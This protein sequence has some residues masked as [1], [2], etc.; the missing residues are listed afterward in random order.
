M[1]AE[2]LKE[3]TAEWVTLHSGWRPLLARELLARLSGPETFTLRA[4]PTYVG[5]GRPWPTQGGARG[6]RGYPI[7]PSPPPY[8]RL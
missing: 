6:G 2:M 1:R 8:L 7:P 5:R 3:G 4:L